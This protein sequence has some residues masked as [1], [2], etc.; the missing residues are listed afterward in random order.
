M[1]RPEELSIPGLKSIFFSNMSEVIFVSTKK[2]VIACKNFPELSSKY[3]SNA[4]CILIIQNMEKD[5]KKG[6]KSKSEKQS[7]TSQ[8]REL[9]GPTHSG[10][11]EQQ[12]SEA[13]KQSTLKKPKQI[14]S[15][16][17]QKSGKKK[18]KSY[19]GEER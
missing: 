8:G 5:D 10:K 2:D 1:N 19:N 7:D 12:Q 18:P 16:G 14:K 11:K 9:C 15:G 17:K 6:G 3:A 13:D 4:K